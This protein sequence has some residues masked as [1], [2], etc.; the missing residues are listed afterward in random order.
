MP[1][2]QCGQMYDIH[3]R[4]MAIFACTCCCTGCLYEH[5]YTLDVRDSLSAESPSLQATRVNAVGRSREAL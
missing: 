1:V 2:L 4:N 3:A 5:Y